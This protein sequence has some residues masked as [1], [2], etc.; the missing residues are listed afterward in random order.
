[1]RGG[2]RLGAGADWRIYGCKKYAA[3]IWH[4]SDARDRVALKPTL[5]RVAI[6]ESGQRFGGAG[7]TI[8]KLSEIAEATGVF[9]F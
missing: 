9:E 3:A 7:Q 1:M 4:L 5:C 2:R 6:A 8:A